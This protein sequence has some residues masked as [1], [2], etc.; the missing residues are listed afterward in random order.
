MLIW[1]PLFEPQELGRLFSFPLECFKDDL[2]LKK[3]LPL[4]NAL[5][6]PTS[7]SEHHCSNYHTDGAEVR[8]MEKIMPELFS[9]P[10]LF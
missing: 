4:E 2:V 3:Y 9:W 10:H 7:C 8:S 5:V 6:R 1:E